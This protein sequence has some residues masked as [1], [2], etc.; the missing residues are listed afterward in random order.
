MVV[1]NRASLDGQTGNYRNGTHE[2][3]RDECTFNTIKVE[4]SICNLNSTVTY[5]TR[6]L[7]CKRVIPFMQS[8]QWAS[9]EGHLA[10]RRIVK[11]VSFIMTNDQVD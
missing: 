3:L 10:F 9:D 4:Y 8:D 11:S 6:K 5:H 1:E 7:P 2:I